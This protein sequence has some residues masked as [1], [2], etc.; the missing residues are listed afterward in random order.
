MFLISPTEPEQLQLLGTLSW[1]PEDYGADILFSEQGKLIGI[2]RKAFP[3]DFLASLHDG[4]LAKEVAQMKQLDI[5]LLMLEGRS[6][7]TLDGELVKDYGKPFNRA[8][9]RSLCYSIWS[10]YG[11]AIDWSDDVG[12]T[13]SAI[14]SLRAWAQRPEHL[15]LARRPKPQDMWGGSLSDK[16]YAVHLLQ[17]L[18]GIG[19]KTAGNIYDAFGCV[20]LQ[21]TIGKKDLAQVPGIG[22]T[23]LEQLW[24]LFEP[25]NAG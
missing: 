18:P 16:D 21:W 14:I 9:L 24:K 8:S 20:P 11:I 10:L 19:P 1:I 6:R 5:A 15:A 7:W 4:R 25:K 22:K 3:S 12:D 2:Q 23:R 17:S 13:A